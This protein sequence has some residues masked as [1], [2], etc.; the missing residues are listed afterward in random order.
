MAFNISPLGFFDVSDPAHPK[1]I[2]KESINIGTIEANDEDGNK[3]TTSDISYLLTNTLKVLNSRRDRRENRFRHVHKLEAQ[4]ANKTID[5]ATYESRKKELLKKSI[6]ARLVVM[7]DYV[8]TWAQAGVKLVFFHSTPAD[9]AAMFKEHLMA[10]Q[11]LPRSIKVGKNFI[12]ED[13][14]TYKI[15]KPG[16]ISNFLTK[17]N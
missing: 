5:K 10:E 7:L 14:P 6:G 11:V 3:Y 15:L 4:W 16:K 12:L 9:V 8:N 17:L 1:E 13:T 2:S